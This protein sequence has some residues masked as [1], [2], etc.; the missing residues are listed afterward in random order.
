MKRDGVVFAGH[1]VHVGLVAFPLGMLAAAA[2]FDVVY[3]FTGTA[4][5]ASISSPLLALGVALALVAAVFGAL[6]WRSIPA[7]TRAKRVATVHGVGSVV[8]VALFAASWLL[9]RDAPE[10]PG[11]LAIACSVLGIG[12][13][14]ATAWLGGELVNRMGVGVYSDAS[15]NAPSSLRRGGRRAGPARDYVPAGA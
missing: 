15:L 5:W 8:M 2:I 11:L 1:R 12:L 7:G 9:R 13:G 6:D 3:W 14:T 4:R 10:A